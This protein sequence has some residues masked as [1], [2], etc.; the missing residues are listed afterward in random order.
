[1][2]RSPCRQSACVASRVLEWD[3][4]AV[5]EEAEAQAEAQAEAEAEAEMEEE[6]EEEGGSNDEE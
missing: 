5:E 3:P 6:D 1:M 2:P 4:A